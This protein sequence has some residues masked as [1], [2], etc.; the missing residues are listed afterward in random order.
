MHIAVLCPPFHSHV[1][2]MEA[3]AAALAVRGHSL[4]LVQRPEV[5]QWLGRDSQ[6]G[7]ASVPGG[8]EPLARVIERAAAPAFPFGIRRVVQD[9]AEET[10]RL[11]RDAPSVLRGLG[12]DA[13]LADQMVPAAAPVAR[14]LDLPLVSVASALPIDPDPALPLPVLPWR[15]DPTPRGLRRNAG[16]RRV[17]DI[18]MRPLHQAIAAESAGAWTRPEDALSPLAALWQLVPSLDFP[19]PALPAIA[20]YVGPLRRA[21]RLGGDLPFSLRGDR[22]VVYASLGTLQGHRLGL[23]RRI[24]RGCA[25]AGAELVVSHCSCLAQEAAARIGADHVVA[26]LPQRAMIARADLVVTHAG[27]NTVLDAAEAGVPVLAL[28]IAFD[29]PGTAAR[30]ARTGMGLRLDHRFATARSIARAVTF[31]LAESRF[32]AGA[33]R[34]G[35]EIEVA[36]G[37]AR[38]ATI[39]EQALAS[40]RPVLRSAA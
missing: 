6:L 11:C 16:G 32:R 14:R 24:A 38:A 26:D 34:V 21:E 9:M 19:R 28:P 40:G 1:A 15:Y 25:L 13:V 30:V 8:A 33:R 4:T 20:H 36:G 7:F 22:P 27:L 2:A 3:L 37:A 18:L 17:S 35:A 10:R 31:L 12:A 39:A 5:G 29:Q 23:F